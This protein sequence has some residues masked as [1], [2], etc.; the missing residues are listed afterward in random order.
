MQENKREDIRE[1][2]MGYMPEGKLL[3]SMS[4]P[5][6]ISMLVLSIYNV[7]DSIFVSRISE[8][9]LTAVSLAFPI[10]SLMIAVGVGTGVGVNA[11]LSRYLGMKKFGMVNQT[12]MHGMLLSIISYIVFMGVGLLTVKSYFA[13]QTDSQIIR[14]VGEDYLRVIIIFSFGSLI[15][16]TCERLLQSTGLTNYTMIVQL[17]GGITNIILDPIFIFGLFS[18]PAMGV[19]GAAVATVVGQVLGAIVGIILNHYK[20][21]EIIMDFRNFK[22]DSGIV[23]NIYSVGLPSIVMSSVGSVMVFLMNKILIGFTQTAVAVFGVMFKLQSFIFMPVFGLSNGMVPIISYNYGARNKQRIKK[24][25]KIAMI[26]ASIMTFIGFLLFFFLPEQLLGLF[27]ASKNMLAIGVKCLRRVSISYFVVGFSIIAVAVFQS[28]GHGMMA[29]MES[30]LRQII[31]LVPSAYLLSK[32]GV[33]E[34]VWYSFLIAE[35]VA[36]VLSIY[37]IRRIYKTQIERLDNYEF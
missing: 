2:K 7:V 37:F 22:F 30:V 3:F 34:N 18:M 27:D 1:N 25:I 23:K 21:K 32:T 9:A 5:I 6:M 16:I 8:D 26:T 29:L 36:A 17:V 31:I 33:L 20:N 35:L 14:E 12:A 15:S 24:T 10:Q 13:S 28:M 11:L 4:F 19:R